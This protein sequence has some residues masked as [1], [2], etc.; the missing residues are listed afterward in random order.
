VSSSTGLCQVFPIATPE[1]T[2]CFLLTSWCLLHSLQT[3]CLLVSRHI[4]SITYPEHSPC[5]LCA[6][7]VSLASDALLI[8][9]T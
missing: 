5:I 6:L 7:Q 8:K 4:L 9:H 3:A 1:T 2:S